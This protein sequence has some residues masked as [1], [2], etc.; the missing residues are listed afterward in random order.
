MALFASI[1]ASLSFLIATDR[2]SPGGT[3]AMI[4]AVASAKA[5]RTRAP[6]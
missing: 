2:S 4:T 6:R 3:F 5:S 1:L